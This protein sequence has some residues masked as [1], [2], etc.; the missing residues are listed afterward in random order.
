[1]NKEGFMLLDAM[2]S[3]AIVS[4]LA[5][6]CFSIYR[7][8]DNDERVME[9]YYQKNNESYELLFGSLGDCAPC[10][11]EADRSKPES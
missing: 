5:L 9:E 1:M 3:I 8:I 6:M 2:L 7:V 11:L 10:V 4:V